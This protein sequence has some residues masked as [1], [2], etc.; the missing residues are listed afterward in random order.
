MA[1]DLSQKPELK[2]IKLTELYIPTEYQRSAKNDASLKNISYIKEHFNWASCGALLVCELAK[3]K[4][5]QYAIID[6]QHRFKAAEAHGEITELPCVVV[7]P[8]D[9]PKQASHFIEV[10]SKRIKLNNLNQYRAAVVAGEPNA[11]SLSEILKKA[12]VSIPTNPMGN[13]D[14]PPRTTQAIGTLLRM[15]ESYSEKQMIWAL[16]IIPEAYEEEPGV[17]RA[18]LL[19]AMAEWIK[20]H[21]DTNRDIMIATLQGID[22]DDLEKDARA[23]RAIDGKRTPEAFMM[24]IE[25]KYN[26]AKRAA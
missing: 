15:L 11:V 10:N 23:Y 3:A 12:K 2:W 20:Q 21:P 5:P 26:A 9:A 1:S 22:L 16:T 13:K 14:C 4:P 18:S 25:R 19:K 8:R 17:M 6:G 24:V 7:S